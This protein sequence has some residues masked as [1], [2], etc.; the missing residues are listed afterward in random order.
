M[1]KLFKGTV[2]MTI[3]A[4]LFYTSETYSQE[5]SLKTCQGIKDRI[6]HY[7]DLRR[8]GGSA[9]KMEVWKQKR[10]DYEEKF[11]DNDCSHWRN[12]LE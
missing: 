6:D 10:K 12:E 5:V 2:T 7:T 8:R 11:S 3:V 9:R 1:K 4:A